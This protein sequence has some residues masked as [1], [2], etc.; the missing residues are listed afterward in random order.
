MRMRLLSVSL[1]LLKCG[2]GGKGSEHWA[3]AVGGGRWAR[4]GFKCRDHVFC[5][6]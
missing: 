6:E 1:I 3:R 5:P 4:A 2:K